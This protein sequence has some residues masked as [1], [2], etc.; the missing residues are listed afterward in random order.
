[1]KPCAKKSGGHEPLHIE[2]A[3]SCY[4]LAA[5]MFACRLEK[6]MGTVAALILLHETAH[7][8]SVLAFHGR[9]ASV[10]VTPF[11]LRMITHGGLSDIEEAVATAA[12][13]CANLFA[14]CFLLLGGRQDA[15]AESLA[16]GLFNLLPAKG[17]DGGRLLC[18]LFPEKGEK[19]AAILSVFLVLLFLAFTLRLALEKEA[20]FAPLLAACMMIWT[21][22]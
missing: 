19:A 8:L 1:M 17:L 12:G 16:L 18:L 9:V 10:R 4:L 22:C 14:S 15:A 2:V 3:P 11:G 13:P 7:A 5:F 6:G 20:F 21:L